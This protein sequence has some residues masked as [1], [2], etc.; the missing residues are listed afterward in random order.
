MTSRITVSTNNRICDRCGRPVPSPFSP[1]PKCPTSYA[2]LSKPEGHPLDGPRGVVYGA[3]LGLT[4]WGLF[5]G[6]LLIIYFDVHV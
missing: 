6:F 1:C 2:V 3:L 5:I 4:M